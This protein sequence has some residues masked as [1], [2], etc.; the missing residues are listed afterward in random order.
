MRLREIQ[1]IKPQ[2]PAQQRVK[3]MSDQAKKMQQKVK[4][5]RA[6][7]A[8]GGSATPW[9]RGK[10]C[11]FTRAMNIE[12][13]DKIV[14]DFVKS[15]HRNSSRLKED[16][17]NRVLKASGLVVMSAQQTAKLEKSLKKL[18]D[19]HAKLSEMLAKLEVN[20]ELKS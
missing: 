17:K 7:Q 16:V 15:V 1:S 19:D 6:K 4:Q 5:E 3:A 20:H 14:W 8:L 12:R 18:Q 2:T 11:G 10:T 9:Q 13:T